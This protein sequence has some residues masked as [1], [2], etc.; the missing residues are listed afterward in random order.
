[1]SIEVGGLGP[2]QPRDVEQVRATRP[3]PEFASALDS[4]RA[5]AVHVDVDASLPDSPP[6]EVT[7]A[8]SAASHAYEQLSATGQQIHF[9]AAHPAGGVAVVVQDLDGNPLS[10]ISVSKALRIASGESL[11]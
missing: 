11:N 2:P 10:T 4:A 7:R 6:P 9:A 3:T 5:A 1:M 8:I